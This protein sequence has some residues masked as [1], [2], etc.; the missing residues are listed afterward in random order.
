MDGIIL[1]E[2]PLCRAW[3]ERI[4]PANACA[5]GFMQFS[6]FS[7]ARGCSISMLLDFYPAMKYFSKLPNARK[8]ATATHFDDTKI[9]NR[10]QHEILEKF[11]LFHQQR[12]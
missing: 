8:P 3:E 1:M 5:H 2:M 4:K 6:Y 12:K 9:Y 7:L 10:P 11:C